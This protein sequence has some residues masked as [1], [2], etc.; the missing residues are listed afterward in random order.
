MLKDAQESRKAVDSII[1]NA[2]EV[3]STAIQEDKVSEEEATEVQT[4]AFLMK[5]K[6]SRKDAMNSTIMMD[7]SVCVKI[8]DPTDIL[9]EYADDVPIDI[10]VIIQ[11]WTQFNYVGVG[12]RGC[13]DGVCRCV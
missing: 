11:L 6:R 4:P 7:D 5:L 2:I 9:K 12:G 8:P 1:F 3:V 10:Q 13:W